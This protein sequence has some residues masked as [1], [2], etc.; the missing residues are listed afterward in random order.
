MFAA[1]WDEFLWPLIVLQSPEKMPM[2]AEIWLLLDKFLGAGTTN[3]R[4]AAAQSR[5]MQQL[6]SAGLSWNGLMVLAFLQSLPIFIVFVLCPRV[7][8]EGDSDSRAQVGDSGRH[9]D[10]IPTRP[11]GAPAARARE[12]HGQRRG[13]TRRQVLRHRRRRLA[14][15]DVHPAAGARRRDAF[16]SKTARPS[17]WSVRR[18]AARA[19][20]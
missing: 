12:N 14:D 10:P 6:M 11:R 3:A 1:T 13:R 19:R 16:G 8:P 5:Q 2:S 18:G 20:C 15:G 4:A 7:P 17:A 9:G